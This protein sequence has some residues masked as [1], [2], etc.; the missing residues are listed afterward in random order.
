MARAD[1]AG[2]P[3]S[4][5]PIGGIWGKVAQPLEMTERRWLFVFNEALLPCPLCGEPYS[6]FLPPCL[7]DPGWTLR[8][9]HRN[10]SW[11]GVSSTS[12]HLPLLEEAEPSPRLI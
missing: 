2:E 12:L 11:G 9:V 10:P 1:R 6:F 3:C 4:L 8:P 5:A 7:C